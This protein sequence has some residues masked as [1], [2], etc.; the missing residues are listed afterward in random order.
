MYPLPPTSLFYGGLYR[1]NLISVPGTH[2]DLD[3][4]GGPASRS[5]PKPTEDGGA[6][7]RSGEVTNGEEAYTAMYSIEDCYGNEVASGVGLHDSTKV[8]CTFP[9]P[10]CGAWTRAQPVPR[11]VTPACRRTTRL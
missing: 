2:F 4:F 5:P 7:L 1:V 9:M 8:T 11:T 3:Y 10:S 6:P